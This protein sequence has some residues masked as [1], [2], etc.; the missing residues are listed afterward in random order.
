M[1]S[2]SRDRDVLGMRYKNMEM[3]GS[4]CFAPLCSS[5]SSGFIGHRLFSKSCPWQ[6]EAA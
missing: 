2:P 4:V 3:D 1:G 6:L 5:I